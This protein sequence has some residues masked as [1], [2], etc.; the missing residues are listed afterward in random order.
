MSNFWTSLE[1]G[2]LEKADHALIQERHISLQRRLEV[3]NSEK[4][5]ETKN[6][7]NDDNNSSDGGERKNFRKLFQAIGRKVGKIC[8]LKQYILERHLLMYGSDGKQKLA[9]A[10]DAEDG[11]NNNMET[12]NFRESTAPKVEG[13]VVPIDPDEIVLDPYLKHLALARNARNYEKSIWVTGKRNVG[14]ENLA[15]SY[16]GKRSSFNFHQH[17]INTM[18]ADAAKRAEESGQN[19]EDG[20][21]EKNENVVSKLELNIVNAIQSGK[22]VPKVISIIISL[23]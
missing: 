5:E 23:L 11:S 1:D 21:K 15:S 14:T 13:M 6:D 3:D 8:T 19:E 22:Q 2:A 16:Q 9:S 4:K 20:E 12:N 7:N 18:L 17:L 10:E